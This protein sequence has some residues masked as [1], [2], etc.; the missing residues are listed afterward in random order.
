MK[1]ITGGVTAA[2]GFQAACCEANIKYKN[3]T[4]MAMV[5]Y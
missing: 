2:Q 5:Y 3:S 1:E 4:D